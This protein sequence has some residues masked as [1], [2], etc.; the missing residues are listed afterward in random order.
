MFVFSN[1]AISIDGK[2]GTAKRGLYRLGTNNDWNE[3][4]RLRKKADAI[5]IGG[6]TFRSLPRAVPG[7]LNVVISKSMKSKKGLII[8]GKKGDIRYSGPKQLLAHLKKR[9]CKNILI[10]GGGEIMWEFVKYIREFH[11][12]LTPK[13]LGGRTAPTLVD[14]RGFAPG[15]ELNLKL[16]AVKRIKNELFLIFTSAPRSN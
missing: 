1:L 15:K 8:A 2:I 13:I 11:V 7:V 3:V 12:T 4:K 10:E 5:I 9:G 6:A 14:G 16:K